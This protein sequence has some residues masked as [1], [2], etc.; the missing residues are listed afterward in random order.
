M[1]T[2][3]KGSIKKQTTIKDNKLINLIEEQENINADT[4]TENKKLE[5]CITNLYKIE[6]ET[7]DTV[8]QLKSEKRL[9]LTDI[10]K[11]K[12]KILELKKT[13]VT[14]IIEQKKEKKLSY[15]SILKKFSEDDYIININ[16]QIIIL[17]EDIEILSIKNN[18]YIN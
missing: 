10:Q 2:G 6:K 16:N 7:K 5:C 3:E 1:K 17:Q 11:K 14:Y 4:T 9:K 13:A 12:K 15:N 18:E 8:K